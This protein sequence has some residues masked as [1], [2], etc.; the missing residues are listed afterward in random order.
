MKSF[1]SQSK[2]Q[3]RYKKV[4]INLFWDHTYCCLFIVEKLQ[5]SLKFNK[6][7][8]CVTLST[9]PYCHLLPPL[10]NFYTFLAHS[11]L[12]LSVLSAFTTFLHFLLPFTIFYTTFTNFYYPEQTFTNFLSN[13]TSFNN[14]FTIF[15]QLSLPS[16]N[17]NLVLYYFY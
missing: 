17:F 3:H 4:V 8:Q 5:N 7:D 11:I 13:L 12:L 2:Y 10:T 1:Y 15:Q 9:T 16:T 6:F 14:F